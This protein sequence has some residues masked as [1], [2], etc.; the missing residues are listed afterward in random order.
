MH[1]VVLS[2]R[3]RIA[4]ER[5][6]HTGQVIASRVY[7]LK[8]GEHSVHVQLRASCSRFVRVELGLFC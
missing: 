8:S 1:D 6:A 3:E 4:Y 5:F 2:Q 7:V